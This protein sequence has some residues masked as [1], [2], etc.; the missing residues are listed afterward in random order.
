MMID[1]LFALV[2][3]LAACITGEPLWAIAASLFALAS[4]IADLARKD[5]VD[6]E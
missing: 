3:V 4:N 6:D 2:F 1:C 5:G